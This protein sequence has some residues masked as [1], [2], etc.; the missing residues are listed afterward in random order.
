MPALRLSRPEESDEDQSAKIE[1]G[2]DHELLRIIALANYVL[3][4]VE[5]RQNPAIIT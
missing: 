1:G 3:A 4:R 5:D 2:T